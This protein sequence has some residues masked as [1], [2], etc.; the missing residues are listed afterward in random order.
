MA[1]VNLFSLTCKLCKIL[2]TPLLLNSI[3]FEPLLLADAS[4]LNMYTVYSLNFSCWLMKVIWICT[5]C[6]FWTPLA[7]SWKLFEYVQSVLLE[8]LLLADE[9]YLNMYTVYSLNFSCW[10]MKVIWICTQCT[11]WTSL[12]GWCK[13]FEYVHSVLFKPL[14]LGDASYLNMYRTQCSPLISLAS[15]CRLFE[16]MYTVYSLNLSCYIVF[17][18]NLSCWLM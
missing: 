10:L 1:D 16:N 7:G 17:S 18:M 11:P 8:L 15:W 13:L 2:F 5:Q 3:L 6:T 12:A 4:Y 9:S 14:L